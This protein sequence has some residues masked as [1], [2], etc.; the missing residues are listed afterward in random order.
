MPRGF[1]PAF[2]SP[3]SSRATAVTRPSVH[4][5]DTST[6][7]PRRR[8]VGDDVV[9]DA[10]LDRD[11]AAGRTRA[12]RRTRSGGPCGTPVHRSP[13]AGSARGRR[14]GGRRAAPIA[15][16][17][18]RRACPRR[19][20]AGRRGAPAPGRAS[21]AGGRRGGARTQSPSSSQNIC[22]RV[23]SGQPSARI[24]GELCSQPPLGVAESMFPKRS[25][26]SRWTVSPRVSSPAPRRHRRLDQLRQPPPIGR[27]SPDRPR[28]RARGARRCRPSR[29]AS[30]G[31]PRRSP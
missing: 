28:R 5:P 11:R 2:S 23:P 22:A 24:T 7:C 31:E 19:G 29:A 1:A 14:G 25:T 12:D 6:S 20:T 9:A 8:Q 4:G 30:R 18:R 13:P 16:A 26:T 15:P 17:G 21:C 10:L 3:S 27:R